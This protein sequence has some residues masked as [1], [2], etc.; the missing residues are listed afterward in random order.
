MEEA[1]VCALDSVLMLLLW[2]KNKVNSIPVDLSRARFDQ[3]GFFMLS[4]GSIWSACSYFVYSL[5]SQPTQLPVDSELFKRWFS[6]N[7]TQ[8][9]A[10]PTMEWV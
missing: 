2:Y 7:K 5:D 4:K 9:T 6:F 10:Q 3:N 8:E 1:C